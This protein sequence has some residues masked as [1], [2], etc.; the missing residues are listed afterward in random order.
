MKGDELFFTCAIAILIVGC[1][2]SMRSTHRSADILDQ[3]KDSVKGYGIVALWD[4]GQRLD[5]A[6]V[7]VSHPGVDLTVNNRFCIGS[8]T[9]MFTAVIVLQLQEEGLL[10]IDGRAVDFLPSHPYI[11]SAITIRQ[12]LNHSSGLGE[13][14]DNGFVNEPFVNPHGDFS[15]P[16]LFGHIGPPAFP[17][18]TRSSYCNSNYFLLSEIVE[19]ITDRSFEANLNE[20]IIGPL[21]LKNTFAY[22][23][24]TIPGLAHPM[25][26]GEDL[27][28]MPKMAGALVSKGS[29][30]V[31]SDVQDLNKFIRALLIERTLLDEKSLAEM[32]TFDSTAKSSMGLGLFE[33]EYA[34][35]RL[36]GHTGRQVSYITYAFADQRTGESFVVI[37]NNANDEVIDVVFE[38]LVAERTIDQGH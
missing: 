4:D 3:Y 14:L 7:G 10:K 28:E 16:V 23:A 12:L 21:G 11:D 17:P 26:D 24:R 15:D 25:L 5:T 36:R 2:D 19:R 8:C 29:G 20:R 38:R 9:K 13:M 1:S 37:N 30:N 31:V 35:R 34:G 32:S 22:H 6:A 33:R 18:G 27:H